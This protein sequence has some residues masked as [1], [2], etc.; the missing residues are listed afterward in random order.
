MIHG[1]QDKDVAKICQYL[2]I[3]YAKIRDLSENN[4]PG[5]ALWGLAMLQRLGTEQTW[6]ANYN[7]AAVGVQ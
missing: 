4:R 2:A 7:E 6:P 5:V 3:L 1:L